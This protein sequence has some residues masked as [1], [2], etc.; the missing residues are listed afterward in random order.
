MIKKLKKLNSFL[1]L[2]NY[3]KE[4][5]VLSAM[6]KTIIL[7]NSSDA[8]A[9]IPQ[10]QEP[11]SFATNSE[12]ILNYIGIEPKEY[13]AG[14][15]S[16]LRGEGKATKEGNIYAVEYNGI[17]A[18]AK[19]VPSDSSEPEVWRAIMEMPLEEEERK[20]LPKIFDIIKTPRGL[21]TDGSSVIVMEKLEPYSGHI[22]SV[23]RGQKYRETERLTM[24][25]EYLNDIIS[26]TFNSLTNI[27][28]I[29]ETNDE[30]MFLTFFLSQKD[31]IRLQL[32]R[33]ILVESLPI[34]QVFSFLKDALLSLASFISADLNADNIIDS[35]AQYISEK[36]NSY[37][38]VSSRPIPKYFS[39]DPINETIGLWETAY[40]GISDRKREQLEEERDT[41]SYE[42]SPESFY[43]SEAYMPETK[44]LFSL[45]KKMKE[46]GI[47]WVDV[48]ANNIMQRPGTKELV[49]I[50]VGLFEFL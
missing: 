3:S 31:A 38:E 16:A 24:N 15:E 5:V 49:L 1:A 36:I 6:I 13:I 22:S 34:D 46:M 8:T 11:F 27:D 25:E 4:S 43:Y 20:H 41:R 7:K 21:S 23:L 40:G 29:P 10:S 2:N 42:V 47:E 28:A 48:H 37:L 17:N 44:S 39:T 19:V 26:K 45:I 32:E 33:Q 12:R 30:E 14:T 50:D 9:V 18:V 35:I